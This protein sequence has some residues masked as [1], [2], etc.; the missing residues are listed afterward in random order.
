MN[1][2]TLAVVVAIVAAG[3]GYALVLGTLMLR[4]AG[5]VAPLWTLLFVGLLWG[6]AFALTILLPL[7]LLR[8][9]QR[10]AG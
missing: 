5:A 8:P 6:T 9:P 1:R 4:T 10:A 7:W 2:V 3:I